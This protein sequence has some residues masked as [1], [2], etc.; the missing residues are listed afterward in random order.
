MSRFLTFSIV[1]ASLCLTTACKE[2]AKSL[3]NVTGK[4]GE[5][6]IVLDKPLWEGALGTTMRSILAADYPF[7]PQREPIFTLFNIPEKTFTSIFQR[8]RN[9]ILVRI[10][11]EVSEANMEIEQNT[12]AKSQIV[13][14]LSGPNV[15]A[16]TTLLERQQERLISA[17]EQAERNRVIINSKRYEDGSLRILVN[18]SFGGSAYFPKGY[19]LRKQA[20]DFIWISYETTYAS[21]GILVYSY[22]YKDSASFSKAVMLRERN[23][24]LQREVPGELPN[25]YM[26]T[27]TGEEPAL[28][29]VHYN[30]KDFAELRGLWEVQNDF[31]GGPFISH[32]YYDARNNRV[33]V[34]EAF[35]YNP[36]S[37][38]RNYMRQ[39]ESILYSFEWDNEQETKK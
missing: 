14:R 39:T 2:G 18:Q 13:I 27:Y 29:W 4:A 25:S 16:I 28:R 5:V 37:E 9:L 20:N 38:K 3:S 19:S 21:Q 30:N 22:P 7:L 36:R 12:W 34:I 6:C 26:T 31:M 24:V 32:S 8:H 23:A 15:E 10:S 35:V 11:S 33:L 17:I 1:I